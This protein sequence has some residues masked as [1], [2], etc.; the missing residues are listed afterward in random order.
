MRLGPWFVDAP[1]LAALLATA[2]ARVDD[3]HA[4]H[5]R[6]AGLDLAA[7][8]DSLAVTAP[9][10]R[11]ALEA[12]PDLVVEHGTVRAATHPLVGAAAPEAGPLL[13]ALD[14]APYAPPSPAELGADPALVRALVRDGTLVDLDGVVFSARALDRARGAVVEAL[15]ERGRLTISDV[16]DVL[17]STRKYVLPIC[18]WLDRQGVTRRRGDDRVPGPA[19]GLAP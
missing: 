8:A 11:A 3:H 7:L 18:G 4:A 5:P 13:A 6:D 1:A 9:Q 14:A 12:D 15:R 16:R 10:L 17:G 19:S 2:R